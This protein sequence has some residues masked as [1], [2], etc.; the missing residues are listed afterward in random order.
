ML[1]KGAYCV[2]RALL[3]LCCAALC[4]SGSITV[5]VN[6]VIDAV[7][8]TANCQSPL[9][10]ESAVCNLRS[11][12]ELCRTQNG[13]ECIIE[14]P[15]DGNIVLNTIYGGRLEMTS[16]LNVKIRG[17]NATVSPTGDTQLTTVEVTTGGFPLSTGALTDTDS[18][19]QNY[20]TACVEGCGGD[21]LAFSGCN[22]DQ[23]EDTVYRLYQGDTQVAA[24]D[25]YCTSVSYIQYSVADGSACL[26]YC[27]RAGCY[28]ADTCTTTVQAFVSQYNPFN[29][30]YY[31]SE[32]GGSVPSL[33]I[34]DLTLS[35]FE[36]AIRLIGETRMDLTRVV[37]NANEHDNGGGIY[38]HENTQT[39]V[40][41]ECVFA[42]NTALSGARLAKQSMHY[43]LLYNYAIYF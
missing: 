3:V 32:G 17:N 31:M 1:A 26:Q 16:D 41:K 12:F 5:V 25:D 21:V 20:Q 22:Y 42:N 10:Q 6:N 13:E 43:Y 4:V 34:D 30:I 15:S 2:V 23:S 7:P 8:E 11:A 35:G 14:L 28:D 39:V 24:N 36:G 9:A 19:T 29:F 37:F 33:S 18:A 27:L 40:I 38:L